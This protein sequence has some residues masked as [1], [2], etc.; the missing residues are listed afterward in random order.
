MKWI[1]YVTNVYVGN[2]LLY[3]NNLTVPCP[4]HWC[5]SWMFKTTTFTGVI[6]GKHCTF[7]R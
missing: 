2:I 5:C 3:K 4:N 1:L 7:Y 6:V